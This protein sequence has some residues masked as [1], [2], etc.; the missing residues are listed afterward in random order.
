MR[1]EGK[2]L[3]ESMSAL[4]DAFL[5]NRLYLNYI[6]SEPKEFRDIKGTAAEH[7]GPRVCERPFTYN[8]YSQSQVNTQYWIVPGRIPHDDRRS[9]HVL[10]LLTILTIS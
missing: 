2:S 6:K 5:L 1:V 9:N 10:F 8:I 7:N 3:S 4:N